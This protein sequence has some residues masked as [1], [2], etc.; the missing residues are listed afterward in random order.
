MQNNNPY[1]TPNATVTNSSLDETKFGKVSLT[2]TKGRIGRLRFFLYTMILTFLGAAFAGALTLIPTLGPI[3]AGIAYILIFVFSIFLTIQRCHD[4]NATGW[5][6]LIMLIPLVSL[7]F[8]FIPGTKGS[9]RF[10]Y[11][12]PPNSKAVKIGVFLI[13]GVVLLGILAMLL[14]PLFDGNIA[15]QNALLPE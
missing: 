6:A 8:Y 7:V 1:A 9:N 12:P 5:W 3:L 10:G 15:Q 2:N 11:Q 13:I 4:F 14:I